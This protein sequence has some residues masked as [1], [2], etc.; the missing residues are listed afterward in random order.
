ME[1]RTWHTRGSL[2]FIL[3][4]TEVDKDEKGRRYHKTTTNI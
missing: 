1:K 4:M 2:K 3:G